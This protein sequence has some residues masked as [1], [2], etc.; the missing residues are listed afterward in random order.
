MTFKDFS[1]VTCENL[2]LS[3]SPMKF[4]S[5]LTDKSS[6]TPEL[7]DVCTSANIQAAISV[8]WALNKEIFPEERTLFIPQSMTHEW[9]HF[10]VEFEPYSYDQKQQLCH[11]LFIINEEDT[12]T[13]DVASKIKLM[14]RVLDRVF[15]ELE[16]AI[17]K[18]YIRFDEEMFISEVKDESIEQLGFDY[19]TLKFLGQMSPM[20]SEL[21]R[22]KFLA[23]VLLN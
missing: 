2:Y 23:R 17:S 7:I 4:L 21:S 15:P 6:L 5:Y 1:R 18:E 13:E 22:E 12:Q 16:S 14:K 20:R 9:G 19:P 3:T 8:T 11:A 10:I